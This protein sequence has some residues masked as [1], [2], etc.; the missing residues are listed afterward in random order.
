MCYLFVCCTTA[1]FATKA[2]ARDEAKY[3][4]L[5]HNLGFILYIM[6]KQ[7]SEQSDKD[8]SALKFHV[9]EIQTYQEQQQ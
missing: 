5:C 8:L 1:A 3:A 9:N 7:A 6:N 4:S 2:G